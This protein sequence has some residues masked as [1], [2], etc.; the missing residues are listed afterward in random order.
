M[1]VKI[2]KP[3]WSAAPYRTS[4]VAEKAGRHILIEAQGTLS[5]AQSLKGL[6]VW[7]AANRCYAEL[8]IATKADAVLQAG[9]LQQMRMDGVGLL[10]IDDDGEV[11]I[12][13]RAR[14]AALVVTPEPTLKFGP[15][16]AEVRTAVQKFNDTDRKDGLRDLCEI[17]ERLTEEL[18]VAACR[19]GYLKKPEAQFI[20]DDWSTQINELA[21][22]EAY[23]TSPPLV[24]TTL[25]DDLHSFRGARNLVDHKARSRRDEAKR[26]RQFAERMM[27]GPRLAAE[28]I[29]L[30]RKLK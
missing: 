2:E 26:Q 15:S 8:Y 16:N 1:K 9:V 22:P 7:L 14:N 3:A 17:V 12:S 18:G 6:A 11:T 24:G 19:K 29:S 30:K 25:K 13:M 5:Y 27:Q 4:V 21:R 10:V 23:H 28:L 20:K